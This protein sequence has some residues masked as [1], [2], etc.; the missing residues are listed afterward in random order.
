MPQLVPRD[1]I[2][3][4]AQLIELWCH[5]KSRYTQRYYRSDAQRFLTFVG[6]PLAQVTLLDVQAFATDLE[7]SGR[8]N[9]SKFYKILLTNIQAYVGDARMGFI[10]ELIFSLGRR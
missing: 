9:A 10:V 1:A 5:G 7:S 2:K 8:A 3:T 6:K 4:D